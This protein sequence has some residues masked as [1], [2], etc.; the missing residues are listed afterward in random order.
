VTAGQSDWIFYHGT[1]DERTWDQPHGQAY[2]LHVGTEESARQALNARIGTP[3]EGDWDGT[4]EYGK[5]LLKPYTVTGA[6][7]ELEAPRYPSGRA[8]YSTGHQVPMDA[9]PGIFPVR[10]TG[11][12]TNHPAIPMDDAHA[13]GRMR[14]QITRGQ[15]RRGYFYRNDGEDYGS[16]S[17]VV[18]SAAHLERVHPPREAVRWQPSS[19]I[20]GPTTG[21]DQDLFDEHGRLRPDVRHCVMT[22]LDQC[23]RT[24]SGLAGSDWQ[25]WTRV[26]LLGG[27]VSE[28]AGPRP[29][30]TARDL[31]VIV[32]IDLR[33]AQ[34]HSAFEGTDAGTAASVLN[35]A[36]HRHFNDDHWRPSFGGTW[37]LTGFCNQRAWDVTQIR[38]YAAYDLTHG[39]WSVQPPHLPGHTIAD[40]DP[41][42]LAQA[43]AV[44]AEARAILRMPEPARTREAR[45]LWDR[46][47]AGRSQAFSP[48]GTGWDDP[49]NLT[50]KWLA[51][52]P[53]HV[54]DHIR[55]LALTRTAAQ[56]YLRNP[57]HGDP[58]FGGRDD[59][60][61]TW[62][63]GT[64]GE[65]DFS[66]RRKYSDEAQRAALPPDQRVMN[67]GWT[68]PNQH[69]G[70]HFSPL[71]EVGHKFAGGGISSTS[72]A[73]VHARLRGG[74]PAHFPT[75]DHLNIAMADWASGHYPHWHDDKLNGTMA[76][77]YSDQEGTHRD[78]SQVPGD[79][80]QR[81]RLGQKAQSLLQW[82]PHMPEILA[83]FKAHLREQGHH[84]IT[85]GNGVEG[86]YD[87]DATRG[88][89]AST[90]AIQKHQDWPRGAPKSI[91]A[92][93]DP[94]DIEVTHVEHIAPWRAEPEPHQRTWED[95]SEHDEPDEVRDRVLDYHRQHG[96]EL[97]G[98]TAAAEPKTASWQPDTSGSETSGVYLRFGHWPEN[99]RSF[100]PAGGYH[101]WGVS[102]YDL[103]RHGEPV[104]GHGLDRDHEHDESC[105]EDCDIP[106]EEYG[107]DPQEEMRGR[108][109]KAEKN[110]R[111]GND[112]PGETG[113]LVRG[114]MSGVGYDGEPLLQ[115][116]RR[117]GD[118]I[119]H[120]HLFIPGAQP[121]RLARHPL[122]E[123]YEEPD[124]TP[125]SGRRTA[126]AAAAA[127]PQWQQQAEREPNRA[128]VSI[129]QDHLRSAYP[130][131]TR[132]LG[133]ERTPVL[134]QM[135]HR[136][137][138][139]IPDEEGGRAWAAPHPH[140]EQRVSQPATGEDGSLGVMLHPEQDNALT[141]AHE[142]AH[143]VTIRRHALQAAARAS[144]AGGHR[145][146]DPAQM[147][148]DDRDHGGGFVWHQALMLDGAGHGD[149]AQEMRDRYPDAVTQV[150]HHRHATGLSR[151]FPGSGRSPHMPPDQSHLPPMPPEQEEAVAAP[152]SR[153]RDPQLDLARNPVPGTR[154]WRGERR[155]F[156]D[157]S[158]HDPD[159]VGIH[160]S[161][162]PHQ[163]I[164]GQQHEGRYPVIWQARVEHPQAQAIPRSHPM[165]SGKHESMPSEK[166]VRLHPGKTVHV[167]GAWVGEPDAD[168]RGA[169]APLHPER[170]GPGW[171]WHPV[172]RHVPVAY[173]G[174]GA[175]DYSDVGIRRE[176]AAPSG[177][178]Q[179]PRRTP[180]NA[181]VYLDV[182]HGTVEPYQGQEGGHHIALAYLPRAI[183]DEDFA[184]VVDR[185]REAATRYPPLRG[186]LGGHLTFPPGA[187]SDKR[188]VAVV[189]ARIPGVHRLQQEF[190][191][192]DR[193][194]YEQYT[195]HVTRAQLTGNDPDPGPHPQVGVSFTHV[196]VRRGDEVHSFP[197]TGLSPAERATQAS[198]YARHPERR[199]AHER[200]DMERRFEQE[201]LDREDEFRRNEEATLKPW[202]R[203]GAVERWYHG[204][205]FRLAEDDLIE[206]GHDPVNADDGPLPHVFFTRSP[207]DAARWAEE[208]SRYLNEEDS[209]GWTTYP[210]VYEVEP[211]G[212]HEDDPQGEFEGDRRSAH[213]LRVVRERHDLGLAHELGCPGCREARPGRTAAAGYDLKPRSGMIYLDLPPGTVRPVPG[214]VDD[215]HVTIVY[216]GSGLSDKAFEEACRR[217]RAAAAQCPPLEGVLRGIGIF[218]PSASSDGK[219][220]AYVPAYIGGVG[221]LRR[222][223]EDLS[224]SEHKDWKPHITLTYMQEGD[225]LPEPHPAVP[226]R[227]TH[228][229]VKRGDD[230]VSFPLT[231]RAA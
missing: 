93:A 18:P 169:I 149:A 157:D 190:G 141:L 174:S 19:G 161:V 83:G 119:D 227:F 67:S 177:G 29:N 127:A 14:A 17:A 231:G 80:G 56:G 201:R 131:L 146:P 218:P 178:Q 66:G 95:A 39:R 212:P 107:N 1:P 117:V 125:P 208:G 12:M 44:A 167:E 37:A 31:D 104:I 192:F 52:A 114:E 10:I 116:V 142:A 64:R 215:H 210:H 97:P 155:D 15:A 46:L 168:E 69:L 202:A 7:R 217:A 108:V 153:H 128:V 163:V 206:P 129:L 224:A 207:H 59:W 159:S 75:E 8:T 70:V 209:P 226:L 211:T 183:G 27:A 68:Q 57:Y 45:A 191:E 223:L 133:E 123:D 58:Q 71:H 193:A 60:A 122:D 40:F 136:A 89:E 105:D 200:A 79:P 42:F 135:L 186:T 110:R 72:A 32:A 189:P 221:R 76:W 185:A 144:Q 21:L 2:G 180:G 197:L 16:I 124:E 152:Y 94:D 194:H 38:P 41:A 213:P 205:P 51:Y 120:R 158:P 203:G 55:E 151:D 165:W 173:R 13:N 137:S 28:W 111:Q 109:L 121:H 115:K 112:R 85:Y 156:E 181:M 170:N 30:G 140:P 26:Y 87:T 91:S 138:F 148:P 182:P 48:E 20:F 228:L 171:T 47:H 230:V 229:H 84:G 175:T 162:V 63:H 179:R 54:L 130:D 145:D 184:K 49:A 86:P 176:A 100:S 214:G 220:P 62:F 118:W 25:D 43:R 73:I 113:H 143:H 103:D 77:N 6:E 90:K 219:V 195:P 147:D 3:L 22:R 9:R 88:G 102:A 172:G 61:Y 50:E 199:K 166:E 101:E 4:R 126:A 53:R 24:D 196:H 164:T 139:I 204:S 150:A 5:T 33:E 92:I 74:S 160:W 222:L 187:P 35:A 99:E 34:R 98:T 36:F 132:P 82:H 11:P 106:T 65:P 216:L 96:G 225:E 23:I 78:F 188:R 134:R 198:E 81:W 154:I